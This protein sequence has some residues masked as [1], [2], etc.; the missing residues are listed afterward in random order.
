MGF[1]YQ[2]ACALLIAVKHFGVANFKSIGIE[3]N[4]DFCILN[5]GIKTRYQVKDRTI[6]FS[7]TSDN[8]SV[9]RVLIG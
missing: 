9:D 6:S 1:K 2:D 8:I 3:T 7:D 4:D 5:D